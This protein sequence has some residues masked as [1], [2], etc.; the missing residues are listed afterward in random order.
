[1]SSCR[2]CRLVKI[3]DRCRGPGGGEERRGVAG[4][5]DWP[6]GIGVEQVVPQDVDLARFTCHV[7]CEGHEAP[8]SF[9]FAVFVLCRIT[10]DAAAQT[11]PGGA[12]LSVSIYSGCRGGPPYAPARS[13]GPLPVR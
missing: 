5:F 3:P 8:P 6:L 10:N 4:V 13:P 2:A 1:M 7:L 9:G 11:L 12:S